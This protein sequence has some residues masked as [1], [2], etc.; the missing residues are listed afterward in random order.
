MAILVASSQNRVLRRS[1][2]V[3]I[4]MHIPCH[5]RK[6]RRLICRWRVIGFLKYIKRI[7]VM[8]E[9]ELFKLKD[10]ID[11]NTKQHSKSWRS[12]WIFMGNQKIIN[13][14]QMVVEQPPSEFLWRKDWSTYEREV[15]DSY[16][17]LIFCA[18]VSSGTEFNF[19]VFQ[20]GNLSYSNAVCFLV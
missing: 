4:T 19:S 12:L 1:A 14:K 3:I 5:V 15:D 18:G 13:Q 9:T 8:E 17:I 11:S 16:L 20:K 6:V 2:S 7:K 10:S